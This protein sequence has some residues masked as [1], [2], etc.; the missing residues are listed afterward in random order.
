MKIKPIILE[1]TVVRLEPLSM[2][3][4]DGL[5]AAGIDEE[6]W[7][8]T[9]TV[10]RNRGD[11]ERYVEA[12]IE[13]QK[14]GK[15]LPFAIIEKTSGRAIGSTRYGNIDG[16]NKSVEIGWTWVARDWQRTPV[17]T[18]CKYLL[19]KHAFEAL[20]CIRVEFKTDS[21]NMQSRNALA[22]IGS[23]EEGILRNHMITPSGRIRHSVYFSIVDSEWVAVKKGLEEKLARPPR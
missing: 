19:L 12:A 11:M 7:R 13:L 16:T 4:V 17:N 6:L 14:E 18:E 5:S 9:M 21:T 10:I 2:S 1:G 3:H 20:G 23:R 15:A 8:Y 22:R